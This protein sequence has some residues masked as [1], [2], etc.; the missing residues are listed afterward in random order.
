MAEISRFT[1]EHLEALRNGLKY[2][3]HAVAIGLKIVE[4]APSE[5][6]LSIPYE[7]DFIGDVDRGVI[8]GGVITAL[9]DNAC[10]LAVH[11]AMEETISIA[12]LD[13]RIDY[14][15]PATPGLALFAHAMCVKATQNIAFV[16]GTAYH[17]DQND[18]IATCV[19][20]FMLGSNCIS[21]EQFEEM[22][23]SLPENTKLWVK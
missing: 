9:L 2:V 10:G 8:H 22:V 15:K 11:M 3:P 18:P 17:L 19:G 5:C 7:R 12:T 13:L 16:R 4:V 14:M 6:R 20:T 21:T 23:K 1:P